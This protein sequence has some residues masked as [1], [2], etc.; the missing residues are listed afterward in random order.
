MKCFGIFEGGGAKGLAHVGALKAAEDKGLEFV[1]VAGTSAGAIIAALVASG[2]KAD[3][4]YQPSDKASEENPPLLVRMGWTELLD[5]ELWPTFETFRGEIKTLYN[6]MGTGLIRNLLALFCFWRK[7]SPTVV[8]AADRHGAF[9]TSR[10]EEWLNDQIRAKLELPQKKITFEQLFDRAGI[11]LKIAAVDIQSQQL[12]EYSRTT[13]PKT[14]VANAVAASISIPFFFAPTIVDDRILVDGGLISNFP[15]WLFNNERAKFP[16]Y[17]QT[18]GFSLLDNNRLKPLA[19]PKVAAIISYAGKVVRTA[20]FG[21]QALLNEK[22]QFLHIVP[23]PTT[24][25]VLDFDAPSNDRDALYVEGRNAT[26]EYFDRH[27]LRNDDAIQVVLE[28]LCKKLR[29][30]MELPNI[31]LRA[32][33]LMPV[34]GDHLQVTYCYNM[35]DDSD[36]RLK[37][38]RIGTGAGEAFTLRKITHT[39][40]KVVFS[41]PGGPSGVDKYNK[42]LVRRDLSSLVSIPIFAIRDSWMQAEHNRSEPIAVLSFDSTER[43][44]YEQFEQLHERRNLSDFAVEAAML[45]A[46]LLKGRLRELM[47]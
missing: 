36:D 45:V 7:W 6:A 10:F 34:E 47:R 5:K 41:T 43:A 1:G 15:A 3:E 38:S 9:S 46:D 16:P 44:L 42:A 32:N 22:V 25:G 28:E 20:S 33:I 27:G 19:R 40:L 12:V 8:A 17:I 29:N 14:Y 11:E 18:F 35:N 26:E 2:F 37:L 39:D 21:G 24:L 13:T 31:H 4:I 23:I 30:A